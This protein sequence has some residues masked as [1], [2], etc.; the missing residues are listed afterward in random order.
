MPKQPAK[1]KK[2]KVSIENKIS[3]IF[4]S[5]GFI[6]LLGLSSLNIHS[7]LD[8]NKVLG[9]TTDTTSSSNE[10]AFWEAFLIENED[11]TEGWLELARLKIDKGDFV[12]AGKAINQMEKNS[13]NSERLMRLKNSLE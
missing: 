13:P 5:L 9:S 8:Q 6:V 10:I 3:Y 7:Y 2:K 12:G 4:F 11:Y 1:G